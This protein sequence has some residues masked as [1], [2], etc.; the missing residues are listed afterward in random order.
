MNADIEIIMSPLCQSV[1]VEGKTVQI[2]IYKDNE[3]GWLLEVVDQ[4][5]NSTV[6][7]D[8]FESDKSALNEVMDTIKE[9]GISS[10]IGKDESELH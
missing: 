10:L 2:D 8:S 5:N 6:W 9:E 7:K 3:G 1:T 4:Y